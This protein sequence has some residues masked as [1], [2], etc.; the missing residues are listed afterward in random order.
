M[1]PEAKPNGKKARFDD[2][3]LGYLAAAAQAA[4]AGMDTLSVEMMGI[5]GIR[6][7]WE[8]DG[9]K[10]VRFDKTPLQRLLRMELGR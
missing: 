5:C 8:L 9:R 10:L 1:T 6:Y 2:F 7:P 3:T 4:R